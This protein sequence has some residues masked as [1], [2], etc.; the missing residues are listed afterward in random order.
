MKFCFVVLVRSYGCFCLPICFE[1]GSQL[2]FLRV[3]V[4][5]LFHIY[6]CLGCPRLSC[7]FESRSCTTF[8]SA[9]RL[10]ASVHYQIIKAWVV[11][12]FQHAIRGLYMEKRRVVQDLELNLLPSVQE[13]KL[14]VMHVHLGSYTTIRKLYHW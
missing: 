14:H 8:F 11:Y 9:C 10:F 1:Q 6:V 13:Y 4:T 3:R 5:T 7:R 12:L 2:S